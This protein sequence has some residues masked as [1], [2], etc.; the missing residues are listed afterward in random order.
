MREETAVIDANMLG[1]CGV[2]CGYCLAYKKTLCLGCRYEASEQAQRGNKDWCTLLN[3]SERKHM[4]ECSDCDEFPCTEYD[5]EGTGMYSRMYIDYINY[6]I[7]SSE[8]RLQVR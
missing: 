4:K 7:K 2:Y 3:C 1:P 8:K 5:P 6:K